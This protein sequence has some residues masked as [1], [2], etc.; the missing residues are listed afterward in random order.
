MLSLIAR[1]L[2]DCIHYC[3]VGR[4]QPPQRKTTREIL[5][6]L[7]ELAEEE[8]GRVLS[9]LTAARRPGLSCC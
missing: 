5:D 1:G 8:V 9:H 2:Y 3:C 6:D 7:E 4:P